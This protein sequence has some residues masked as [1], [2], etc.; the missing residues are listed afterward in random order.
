MTDFQSLGASLASVSIIPTRERTK[1]LKGRS[2]EGCRRCFSLAI[3]LRCF[4]MSWG[5]VLA[6]ELSTEATRVSRTYGYL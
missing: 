5:V 2:E 4:W 1:G 6:I 3:A